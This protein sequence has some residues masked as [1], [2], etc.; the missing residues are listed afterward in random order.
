MAAVA[1]TTTEQQQTPTL[2][3]TK[4]RVTRMSWGSVPQVEHSSG[5]PREPGY[6]ARL[7]VRKFGAA[8]NKLADR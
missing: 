2:P 1:P 6:G 5:I 4:V 7:A 8:I 3:T